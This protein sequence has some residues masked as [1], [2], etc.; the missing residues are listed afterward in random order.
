M[1]SSDDADQL[2]LLDGLYDSGSDG[3]T[4][5]TLDDADHAGLARFG[6]ECDTDD[7]FDA[8]TTLP[9]FLPQ[10]R[11]GRPKKAKKSKKADKGKAI[12]APPAPPVDKASQPEGPVLGEFDTPQP[13][14]ITGLDTMA[15]IDGEATTT[16]LSPFS[17][18]RMRR[19][20]RSVSASY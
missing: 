11:P 16:V 3:D 13:S 19:P 8:P 9:V 5:D 4:T 10:G 2:L 14:I 7:E 15:V 6:I 1:N 18:T 20:R 12:E 17:V